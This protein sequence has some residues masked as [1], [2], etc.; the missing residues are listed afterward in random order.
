MSKLYGTCK[1]GR[2]IDAKTIMEVATIICG[3]GRKIDYYFDPKQD[4]MVLE[5]TG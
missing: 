3:C 4:K 1:C 5:I 2:R